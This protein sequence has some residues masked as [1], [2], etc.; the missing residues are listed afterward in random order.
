VNPGGR[1]RISWRRSVAR[2]RAYAGWVLV[3]VW[4]ANQ[5][6]FAQG[7][8]DTTRM[9]CRAAAALVSARGAIVL[10]TGPNTY[11]RYVRGDGF[12][13]PDE[14]TR[15]AFV[16]AADNPQCFIGYYCLSRPFG[17]FR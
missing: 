10:S 3:L 15:P 8:P 14:V 6:A 16:P 17:S 5:P 11:D 4:C 12:C 9:Q 1:T 7:R 13:L 2:A